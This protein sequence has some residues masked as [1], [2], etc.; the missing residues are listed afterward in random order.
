MP[1]RDGRRAERNSAATAAQNIEARSDGAPAANF[2]AADDIAPDPARIRSHVDLRQDRPFT[3]DFAEV[4]APGPTTERRGRQLQSALGRRRALLNLGWFAMALIIGV[5]GGLLVLA[6]SRV[7]DTFPAM[8][9]VY[10]A[11]GMPGAARGLAFEDIQYSWTRTEGRAA[12]DVNGAI[13]NVSGDAQRVP[14]VVFVLMDDAG[15]ELFT[16]ARRVHDG[17]LPPGDAIAFAAQVPAPPDATR[18]LRVRFAR[19]GR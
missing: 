15:D 13:R 3:T 5:L 1:T 19:P 12:I 2:R 4:T 6:P 17:T 8:A 7:V 16:W 9:R 18:R 14:T 10:D 11:L